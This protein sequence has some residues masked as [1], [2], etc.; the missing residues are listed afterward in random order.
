MSYKCNSNETNAGNLHIYVGHI[1]FYWKITNI[2]QQPI[3]N[4]WDC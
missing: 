4:A 2:T 3:Q 1:N